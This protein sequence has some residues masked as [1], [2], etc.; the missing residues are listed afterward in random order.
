MRAVTFTH[1]LQFQ[2]SRLARPSL[3]PSPEQAKRPAKNISVSP[4]TTE[5]IAGFILIF[6]GPIMQGRDIIA[7]GGL[8]GL[9]NGGMELMRS[10]ASNLSTSPAIAIH[11]GVEG[12]DFRSNRPKI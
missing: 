5:R 6:G 1:K 3:A 9:G 11:I 7:I 2:P 10:P 12:N 4:V 8:A